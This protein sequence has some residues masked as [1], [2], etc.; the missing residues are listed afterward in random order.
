MEREKNPLCPLN[1]T[2]LAE[3]R[4]NYQEVVL[5][6]RLGTTEDRDPRTAGKLRENPWNGD[7]ASRRFDGVSV[8]QEASSRRA[9]IS[10]VSYEEDDKR[11]Q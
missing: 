7:V 11:S 8:E 6:F 9:K 3:Y 4:S 1:K 10:C 5:V 2:S